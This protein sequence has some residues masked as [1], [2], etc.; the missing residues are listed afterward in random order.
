VTIVA[1]VDEALVVHKLQ[2]CA[3]S[4]SWR[5]GV[6]CNKLYLQNTRRSDIRTAEKFSVFLQKS[7]YAQ[8]PLPTFP[9][10]FHVDGEAADLLATRPTSPQQVVVMEFGKRHDTTDF[11]PRQ[12]VIRTCRLCCGL[13]ADV[14]YTGKLVQ[15]ILVYKLH[16][17]RTD[18]NAMC[19]PT[20]WDARQTDRRNE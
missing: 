12:L 2:S 7:W 6:C 18:H 17:H 14:L 8:N 3:H 9:R 11:C 4:I 5:V 19:T 10:N 13:L 16:N 15:W 20:A 1:S